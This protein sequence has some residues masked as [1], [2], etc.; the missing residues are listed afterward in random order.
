MRWRTD[1]SCPQFA[2][3]DDVHAYYS[4]GYLIDQATTFHLNRRYRGEK[5]FELLTFPEEWQIPPKST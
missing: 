3:K 2:D 1:P 5:R 4:G